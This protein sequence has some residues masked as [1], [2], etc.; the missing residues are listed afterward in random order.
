MAKKRRSLMSKP[1]E[2]HCLSMKMVLPRRFTKQR[3]LNRDQKNRVESIDKEKGIS[4]R[5]YVRLLIEPAS[6]AL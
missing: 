5:D 1:Q 6:A 2:I 3:L 4:P